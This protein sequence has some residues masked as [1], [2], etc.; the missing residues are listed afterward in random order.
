MT[1]QGLVFVA[2]LALLALATA[3]C[4]GA[5]VAGHAAPAD[6]AAVTTAAAAPPPAPATSTT[7]PPAAADGT[8]VGACADSNCEIAVSGPVSI[9]LSGYAGLTELDIAG[10]DA[11][12]IRFKSVSRNGS[13]EGS[14]GPGCSVVLAES[15]GSSFCGTGERPTA[16]GKSKG[17]Q[18]RVK[19]I[20][21]GTA[22]VGLSTV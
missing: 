6:S 13:G 19:S 12:R 11:D 3:G 8:D 2:L 10:V 22:V 21:G 4:S 5:Q 15:S 20:D 7:A 1:K 18:I 14:T 16:L 9:P 17:V